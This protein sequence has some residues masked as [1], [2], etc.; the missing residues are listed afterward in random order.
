[1]TTAVSAYN[2]SPLHSKSR[3]SMSNYCSRYF[4]K[5]SWPSTSRTEFG[6]VFVKRG[7]AACAVVDSLLRGLFE[8]KDKERARVHVKYIGMIRIDVEED[9]EM[10]VM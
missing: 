1:M 3:I 4:F 9:S 8:R 5:E 6:I 2:L 10:D 7:V